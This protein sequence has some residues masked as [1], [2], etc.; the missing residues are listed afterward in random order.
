MIKN[1]PKVNNIKKLN[2]SCVVVDVTFG[3]DCDFFK[4]HFETTQILPGIGQI[5][6]AI[7]LASEIFNIDE[8]SFTNIPQT[9]FKKV[10]L[11]NDN[12]LISLKNINN[13]ISFEY[14]LNGEQASL[15]KIKYD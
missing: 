1:Y 13:T 11:P 14:L 6:F 7:K 5:S 4:G 12:I 15:G 10:I 8:E 2:D 9:K 3:A